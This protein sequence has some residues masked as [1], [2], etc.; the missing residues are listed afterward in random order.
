MNVIVTI[1]GREA[2]PVRAIPF[3]TDWEVMSPDVVADALTGEDEFNPQFKELRAYRFDDDTIKVVNPNW[4]ANFPARELKALSDRIGQSEISHETGYD[5]WRRDSLKLLP[6]GVFVWRDEFET[7]F[8]RRFGPEVET[9]FVITPG[10]EFERRRRAESIELNYD[11]F[12]PAKERCE[13][14]M[15]GFAVQSQQPDAQAAPVEVVSASGADTEQQ[16]DPQRRLARLLAGGG[17]AKYRHGEW[18]F[19]GIAAL[20]VS[21]KAD[22]RKRSDEKTIRKDLREAAEAERDAKRAGPFQGLGA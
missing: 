4:W 1:E 3:L 17:S 10:G 16:P 21:E 13:L 19:T 9:V 7:C 6:A 2:I 14:V 18:K 8:W 12:I 5:D 20:V 22:R 11:P 15:D